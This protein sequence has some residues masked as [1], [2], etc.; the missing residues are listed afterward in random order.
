MNNIKASQVIEQL[1]LQFMGWKDTRLIHRI[2][3]FSR[4]EQGNR[5][6]Q[7][8]Y[9][10]VQM[11][12]SNYGYEKDGNTKHDDWERH[13]YRTVHIVL[14]D[15]HYVFAAVSHKEK[16]FSTLDPREFENLSNHDSCWKSALDKIDQVQSEMY[17]ACFSHMPDEHRKAPVY[18][19]P[20]NRLDVG[21]INDGAFKFVKCSYKS[22]SDNTYFKNLLS[23]K[24]MKLK[25][26]LVEA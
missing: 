12:M 15:P 18:V 25:C 11:S 19:H 16:E 1:F 7:G 20:H 4:D 6:A 8:M 22:R 21:F 3:Q 17:E 24:E 23:I 13:A 26:E 9:F 14:L 10:R 5:V 2:D